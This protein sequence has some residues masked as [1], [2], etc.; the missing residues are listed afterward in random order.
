MFLYHP[1]SPHYTKNIHVGSPRAVRVLAPS[2][3]PPGSPRA[4]L[5]PHLEPCEFWPRPLP[6]LV[7]LEPCGSLWLFIDPDGLLEL[8]QGPQLAPRCAHVLHQ[9]TADDGD[10]GAEDQVLQARVEP[11][12][13]LLELFVHLVGWSLYSYMYQEVR[14]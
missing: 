12:A 10:M 7:H 5:V 3:P 9:C 2:F 13:Q 11:L 4:V 8:G 1:C 14:A 6:P